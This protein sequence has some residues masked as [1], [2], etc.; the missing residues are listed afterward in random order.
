MLRGG[1][2]YRYEKFA[3]R[4]G[5]IYDATPQP[6]ATV[7][8]MLAD[9]NRIEGTIGLG[10]KFSESWS[11]DVAY[12]FISVSDRTVTGPTTGDMNPF[13]GTYKNSAN[14]FALS[15]GYTM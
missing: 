6:N 13:P 8:P 7:E 4:L 2:E 11:A 14:L 15:I 12:Q 10:Y 9:A 1:A 5:V 3:F